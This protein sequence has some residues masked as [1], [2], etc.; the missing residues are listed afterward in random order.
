[1]RRRKEAGR[2]EKKGIGLCMG[3]PFDVTKGRAL[4]F[5]QFKYQQ[6]IMKSTGNMLVHGKEVMMAKTNTKKK[7]EE[8]EGEAEEEVEEE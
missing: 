4:Q 2:N 5:N 8:E 6:G 3:L 7:E 1:M